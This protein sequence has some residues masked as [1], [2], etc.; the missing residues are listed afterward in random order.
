MATILYVDDEPSVGLILEDTLEQAGHTPVGARNV[1]EA[2]QVL[3]R[4]DVDL[5]IS[6]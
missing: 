2:L 5:V 6:D 4:G 3:A 1:P